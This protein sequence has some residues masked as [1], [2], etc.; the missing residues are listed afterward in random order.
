MFH[1]ENKT[2]KRNPQIAR[3]VRFDKKNISLSCTVTSTLNW[4]TV[5]HHFTLYVM[6]PF[7]IV[8]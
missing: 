2:R 4:A 8:I 5:I 6:D 1:Y 7:K 3:K